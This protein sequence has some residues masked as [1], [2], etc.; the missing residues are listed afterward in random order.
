ML[1]VIPTFSTVRALLLRTAVL[2]RLMECMP[3]EWPVQCP[4]CGDWIPGSD[5]EAHWARKHSHPGGAVERRSPARIAGWLAFVIFLTTVGYLSYFLGSDPP[6]DLAYRYS[7]SIAG[8]V[9]F[10]IMF[11]ILLLIAI[12]LPKRDAFGLRRPRSWAIAIGLVPLTLLVVY[13]ASLFYS[14]G[15]DPGEEQGLVPEDWDSSRAGAF[16]AYFAVVAVLAPIVEELM[17]RGLGFTLLAPYGKWV[18]ILG[19]GVLFGAAHGLL[20][21]LPLLSLFG[22]L[23]GWVRAKTGSVYPCIIIHAI[24]NAI[25][26]G[27]SVLA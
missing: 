6:D 25:A 4:A 26:L 16:A 27:V 18:A 2:A 17:Y 3:M 1:A 22:I 24:F 23:L 20:I 14:L 13:A 21:A 15:F 10:A 8:V 19:T 11:G 12:G 7:S 9:Q 5:Y